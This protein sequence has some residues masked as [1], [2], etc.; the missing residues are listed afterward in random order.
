MGM[1]A[2]TE[3]QRKQYR[4]QGYL[5]FESIFPA[6]EIDE[7][8]R[9]I[10]AL[11]EERERKL[12]QFGQEGISI[13]GQINFT[14]SLAQKDEYI[15][16]F[17]MQRAFVEIA[18]ALLGPNV[19]VYWDQ[20]VYKRPEAKRDFPWHQDNGYG[21]I[22]PLHYLTCWIA[23]EDVAI[24]NGCIWIQ[25]GTHRQG[26]VEHRQTEVGKQCYFGSDPGMP[27]PLKKGGMAVFSSL[28]FHRSTA[29]VSS[30]VRKG[31]ILQYSETGAYN[32]L[33]GKTFE[34][35]PIILEDGRPVL[36]ASS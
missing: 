18:A 23:L 29:N 34:N 19:R 22:E 3:V 7:L 15:R 11:D 32:P 14:A 35:G 30:S 31:Y 25:P 21:P 26:V 28:L 27:V 5:I 8:R 2:I 13:P 10:D 1:G 33:T 6:G 4:E 17:S 16:R 20:S 24:D 9:R 36:Q 12:R